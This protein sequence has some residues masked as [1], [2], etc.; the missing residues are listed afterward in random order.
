MPELSIN[1][2]VPEAPKQ[3]D[4]KK[5]EEPKAVL[6]LRPNV[7]FKL[8]DGREI[9]MGKPDTPTAMLLPTVVASMQDPNLKSDPA[10]NEFNARMAMFVRKINNKPF[11]PPMSAGDVSV[12]LHELGEDGC[13]IVLDI[14]FKHFAPLNA[15][16]IEIIKK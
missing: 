6:N 12:I 2:T 4:V 8:P 16:Q 9:E 11:R 10:R 3:E 14:Y 1:P 7:S 13:D 5:S 15:D